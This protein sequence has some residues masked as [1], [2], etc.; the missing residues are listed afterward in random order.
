MHRNSDGAPFKASTGIAVQNSHV[1]D[2]PDMILRRCR[3]KDS[4]KFRTN[5]RLN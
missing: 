5:P 4:R 3:R 2:L 1:H